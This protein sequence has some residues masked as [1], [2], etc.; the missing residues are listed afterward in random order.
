V[1]E[2]PA[3]VAVMTL[4]AHGQAAD[5]DLIVTCVREAGAVVART[6]RIDRFVPLVRRQLAAWV[7]DP[8]VDVIIVLGA[9]DDEIAAAAVAPL[10]T[11]PLGGLP[12][13]KADAMRCHATTVIFLHSSADT[14]RRAFDEL[15]LPA[16]SERVP[17][18]RPSAPPARAGVVKGAVAG[19]ASEPVME[20]DELDAEELATSAPDLAAI[21]VAIP[22]ATPAATPAPAPVAVAAPAAPPAVPRPPILPAA[23]APPPAAAAP[24]A[25]APP[26]AATPRA[27]TEAPLGAAAFAARPAG[28]GLAPKLLVIAAGAAVIAVGVVFVATR[29]SESAPAVVADRGPPPPATPAPPPPV[30]APAPVPPE[31]AIDA[32]QPDEPAINVEPPSPPDAAASAAHTPVSRPSHPV[33]S[34]S[35]HGHEHEPPPPPPPDAAVEA[36]PPPVA[37]DG[38][39]EVSCV[40]DHYARPC[41]EAFKPKAVPRA[42]DGEAQTLDKVAV[43]EAIEPVKPVV[44]ACGET[45]GVKGTVKIALVVSPAGA[46]TSASVTASPTPDLGACVATALRRAHFPKTETGASFVYPFVF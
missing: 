26:P 38:C 32:A 14:Q 31:P 28:I 22:V 20:L 23:A 29:S 37:A 1:Q 4:G 11:E 46:V 25:P 44:I 19:E 3:R 35:P 12:E 7:A 45:A 36:P 40:L 8:T 16:L 27:P 41:C 24:R 15:I 30:P 42:P 34:P 10:V 2:P 13:A 21:P 17:A 39:D 18:A 9:M 43:H 6:A 5:P 33:T